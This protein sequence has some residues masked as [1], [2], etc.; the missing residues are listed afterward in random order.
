MYDSFS[1]EYDRFVNWKNR[2]DFEIPFIIEEIKKN[3]S[4]KPSEIQILD[5]ATGT[6][7]HAIAL[8]QKG[9][10]AW[11][12]DLSAGMI[13]KARDNAAQNKVDCRFEVA[14]FGRISRMLLEKN[15]EENS[16]PTQ[17]D[18]VLCLGNSLPH[19]NGMT[20][21][22]STL[23]DFARCL[24]PDGLLLVQ[25][26]NFD[27]V[28]SSQE[29]WMEPQ[30]F[31]DSEGEWLYLRMYDF[32]PDG[33]IQF[34]IITLSRAHRTENWTQKITENR[35]FPILKKDMVKS[36]KMAGFNRINLYGSLANTPFDEKESS[37]LVVLA[38]KKK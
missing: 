3:N 32:L 30:S 20:E 2:L 21:L 9:Y 18:V 37:N 17:F 19:I 11:G 27:A 13:Q 35:L 16:F 14:G 34:N 6:G 7:M 10:A 22:D 29:R 25:N 28:L 1:N 8:V 23:N 31:I 12:V 15:R 26:R 33:C 36:L 38:R 4:N 24:K 5:T